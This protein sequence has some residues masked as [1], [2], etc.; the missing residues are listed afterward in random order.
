MGMLTQLEI[1][2]DLEIVEDFLSHYAIMCDSMEPLAINMGNEPYYKES[3][4]DLFRIYH[5][6][7][8]SSGFL[9]L[10]PIT[11]LA[12]LGEEI[13]E[14]ART[15]TGP[16]NDEFIDWLLLVSDQFGRYRLDIEEDRE[17]F[18]LLDPL[19]IKLP[20]HLEK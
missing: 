6:I 11:K 10:D 18:S 15:I 7:K 12:S 1:D 17:H 8:S 14:E 5:N 20:T 19:I 2:Y 16:A 4:N 3:V 13:L 9:K